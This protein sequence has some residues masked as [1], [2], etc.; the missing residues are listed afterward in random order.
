MTN[1]LKGAPKAASGPTRCTSALMHLSTHALKVAM[2][3]MLNVL[4]FT[5]TTKPPQKSPRFNRGQ[6]GEV[7]NIATFFKR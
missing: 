1:P 2:L 3:R 5:T 6:L 7:S 4:P